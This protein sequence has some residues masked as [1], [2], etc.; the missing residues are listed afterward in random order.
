[1]K[2]L[3]F[4]LVAVLAVVTGCTKDPVPS[5]P[6]KP[7]EPVVITSYNVVEA[8]FVTT[9]DGLRVGGKLFLPEGK[10]G[11]SPAVIFC[12]GLGGTWEDFVPYARAAA[13]RGV[14]CCSFDF[15]GGH[16]GE[17]LSGGE[18]SD[19]TIRTELLDLAAVYGALA[20]RPDVDPDQILLMGGSQG[21]LVAALYAAEHPDDI[22]ALGLMFPAFNLPEMVRMYVNIYGGL[23]KLPASVS[24]MSFTFWRPYL[25]DAYDIYPF[26]VI[27]KFEGPVLILHGDSDSLVPVSYSDKAVKTYKNASLVVLP[28][29]GHG[30]TEAGVEKA[31]DYLDGFL[32]DQLGLPEAE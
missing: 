30:F 10:Q 16:Y 7:E 25:V 2:K 21:G 6:E 5:E 19:N 13:R 31:I 23:D 22:K 24:Y 18:R 15:C 11:E 27:N 3:Q 20:E 9:R 17:S 29:Q 32:T 8:N 4:L 14:I 28:N 1:M 26:R 12:H